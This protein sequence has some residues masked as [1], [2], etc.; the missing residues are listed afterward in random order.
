[1]TSLTSAV[2][3]AQNLAC[4]PGSVVDDIEELAPGASALKNLGNGNY[5]LNWKTPTS[6][7]NSCKTLKLDIGDGVTHNALSCSSSGKPT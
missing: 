4:A 2:V 1:V 5:Q 7:A 6:Y 3:T